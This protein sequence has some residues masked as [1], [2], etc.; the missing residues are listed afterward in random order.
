M[1]CQGIADMVIG[2]PNI[3][4]VQV[5]GVDGRMILAGNFQLFNFFRCTAAEDIK[6]V[7]V[8]AGKGMDIFSPP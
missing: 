2:K 1:G 5:F 8:G 3:L 4:V 6:V 7:I